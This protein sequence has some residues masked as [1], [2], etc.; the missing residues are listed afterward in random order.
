MKAATVAEGAAGPAALPA[1]NENTTWPPPP[2]HAGLPPAFP[3][4]FRGLPP[5]APQGL[6]GKADLWVCGAE[7]RL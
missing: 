3:P 2:P 5:P 6:E 4:T 7:A 1:G